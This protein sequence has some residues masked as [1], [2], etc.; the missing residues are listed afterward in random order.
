[1]RFRFGAGFD[2]ASDLR[3]RYAALLRGLRFLSR[4]LRRR[5]VLPAEAACKGESTHGNEQHRRGKERDD[6]ALDLRGKAGSRA[7]MQLLSRR[8]R[9]RG[10]SRRLRRAATGSITR[11]SRFNWMPLAMRW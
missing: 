11:R 5:P 8:R 9:A 7:R 1:M 6:A 10:Q 4:R 3:G 2:L